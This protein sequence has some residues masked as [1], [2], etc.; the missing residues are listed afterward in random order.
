M[1]GA[2]CLWVQAILILLNQISP[3]CMSGNSD[4]DWIATFGSWG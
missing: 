4:L 1:N 3:G 2:I